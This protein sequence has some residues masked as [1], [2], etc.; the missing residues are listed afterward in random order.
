MLD[1]DGKA[2]YVVVGE[3]YTSGIVGNLDAVNKIT[4]KKDFSPVD[5]VSYGPGS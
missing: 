3:N 1:P 2:F 5:G 4:E